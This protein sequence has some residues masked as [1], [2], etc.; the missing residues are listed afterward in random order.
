MLG[1]CHRL[2]QTIDRVRLSTWTA[3]MASRVY[4]SKG[5]TAE[6]KR[7]RQA[8]VAEL[9]CDCVTAS[10]IATQITEEFGCNTRTAWKDIKHVRTVILPTWYL[11]GDQRSMAIE[12][13]AKLERIAHIAIEKGDLNNA[14]KAIRLVMELCGLNS[15]QQIAK[16]R[17]SLLQQI[18]DMRATRER[19]TGQSGEVPLA[20]FNQIRSMFRRPALTPEEYATYTKAAG[21]N[22]HN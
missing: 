6:A 22:G 1:H 19:T 15:A 13:V 3:Q 7:K 14:I 2:T 5:A 21:S 8:R 9:L 4:L 18:E 16:G 10:R 12:S 20:Q 11:W 17:D